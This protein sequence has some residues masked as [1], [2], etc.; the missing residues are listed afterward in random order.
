MIGDAFNMRH[1]LTG[2]G[3]TVALKDVELL[4]SLLKSVTLSSALEI[5]VARRKFEKL[6]QHHA[7]TVNILANALYHVFSGEEASYV[8]CHLRD[9]CFEYLKMESVFSAGP[10]GLLAGLTPKPHILVI[11]FFMVAFFGLFQALSTYPSPNRM[12][13]SY[14]IIHVACVII[15][16]LIEQQNATFLAWKPARAFINLI[17]PYSKYSLKDF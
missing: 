16:P 4:A 17:F 3:M 9:A 10:I 2:G 13:Q 1:P 14:K 15:M 6:R 8:R 11:H 5:V 12:I 7:S